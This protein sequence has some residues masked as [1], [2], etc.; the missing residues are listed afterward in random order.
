M[1]SFG[2]GRFNIMARG[3]MASGSRMA[4]A[5]R[6]ANSEDPLS[7][8]LTIAEV[9]FGGLTITAGSAAG[10]TSLFLAIVMLS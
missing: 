8:V 7:S 3:R 5:L 10:V 6:A 1:S 4:K 9:A 2:V